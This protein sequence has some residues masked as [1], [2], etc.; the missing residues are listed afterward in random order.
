MRLTSHHIE[1]KAPPN[2]NDLLTHCARRIYAVS[3]AAPT[4]RF[5]ITQSVARNQLIACEYTSMHVDKD[6]GYQSPPSIFRF[7]KRTSV[8]AD[9]FNVVMLVPTGTG[10]A[11]GGHAGDATPVARVIAACCD[12]LITH[13]NVVNA[14]DI[15]EM[16]DN[17]LYVEGSTIARMLMGQI[18]LERVR[19]NR[20]LVIIDSGTG[21]ERTTYVD[22]AINAVNAARYT[23]GL[24]VPEIVVINTLRM[25]STFSESGHATGTIEGMQGVLHAIKDAP[26]HDA[27]AIASV[28]A[29]PSSYHTE[30][31]RAGNHMVN[32]WGGV[33][34]MLTHALSGMHHVP[35]A[36]A[37]VYES[38]DVANIDLGV[39]DPRMA[40]EVVSL[41]FFH[42]VL[43][44]LH[45]SPRIVWNCDNV[46]A[47]TVKDIG[48]LVIPDGC[49]GIPTLAA[50]EQGIPVIAVREN[51]SKMSCNDLSTLPW[52]PGQFIS[53]ANYW[54]AIGVLTAMKAGV[55]PEVM[56]NGRGLGMR[57]AACVR[58]TNYTPEKVAVS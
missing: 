31:Y 52:A 13:P 18:G 34:A 10:C 55:S 54:E 2:N 49:I 51:A 9:K 48:C 11:I 30:Y 46:H 56:R 3:H 53:V 50:L 28:I 19:A 40:A 44:G 6:G 23:L 25:T 14:S 21:A 12:T 41:A 5:A 29:V 8:I 36:H 32:P 38:S 58:H 43:K 33:E 7:D 47:V 20:V 22:M 35:T 15:N 27:I 57:T 45:R 39:V 24:A 16:P 42:C 37:P 17:M 1:I 26:A 4:V